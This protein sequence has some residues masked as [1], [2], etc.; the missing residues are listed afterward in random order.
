M[1]EC[2]SLCI[3]WS[4]NH[5]YLALYILLV[6]L[7]SLVTW[8]VISHVIL[9]T[10]IPSIVTQMTDYP[11]MNSRFLPKHTWRF[12]ERGRE[13]VIH[14]VVCSNHVTHLNKGDTQTQT[15][16]KDLC[17]EWILTGENL[18]FTRKTIHVQLLCDLEPV[19]VQFRYY[20]GL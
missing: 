3:T 9:I 19:Y 20:L 10:Y 12:R 14:R 11:G 8:Q 2:R 17:I 4:L 18:G 6:C 16:G 1:H 5:F 13:D 15:L 7:G